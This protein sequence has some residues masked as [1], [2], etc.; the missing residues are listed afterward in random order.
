MKVCRYDGELVYRFDRTQL[1]DPYFTF[2]V[3][4][5]YVVEV[6]VDGKN[7]TKA[8]DYR[9]VSSEYVE[10]AVNRTSLTID[11]D[12]YGDSDSCYVRFSNTDPA[13]A[14]G[15]GITGFHIHSKVK[16]E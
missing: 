11:P 10:T 6:S 5:N 16:L 3:L 12:D 15:T 14:Y 13:K 8:F 7:Y 4:Y 2:Q 1:N 9:D